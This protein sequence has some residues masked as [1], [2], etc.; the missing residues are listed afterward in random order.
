MR[1]TENNFSPKNQRNRTLKESNISPP[2][3]LSS[4]IVVLFYIQLIR[5]VL[6]VCVCLLFISNQLFHESYSYSH[7][8]LSFVVLF[9]NNLLI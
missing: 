6:C 5:G 7:F 8:V 3:L 9:L 1:I 4:Q 2:V